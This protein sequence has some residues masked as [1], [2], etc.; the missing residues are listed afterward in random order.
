[1]CLY[2]SKWSRKKYCVTPVLTSTVTLK[3]ALLI[4]VKFAVNGSKSGITSCR[5]LKWSPGSLQNKNW[6]ILKVN[7][8]P[9]PSYLT[10][11]H[12]SCKT[13]KINSIEY[14]KGTLF[15][16]HVHLYTGSAVF[17]MDQ[18]QPESGEDSTR[19]TLKNLF[20]GRLWPTSQWRRPT[21]FS[22]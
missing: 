7:D 8:L 10:G 6:E 18:W 14:F 22:S 5:I 15:G 12:K 19:K 13:L 20:F 1:M 16:L 17:G 3:S 11:P 9:L 21:V 4:S 2:V